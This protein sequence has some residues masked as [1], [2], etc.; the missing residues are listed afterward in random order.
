MATVKRITRQ[1]GRWIIGGLVAALLF[2]QL[3]V[4]AY[5]CPKLD[6]PAHALQMSSLSMNV[7]PDCHTGPGGMD[8]KAPQLCR[9]HCGGDSETAPSSFA[10]DINSLTAQALCLVYVVPAV[11]EDSRSAER[12]AA[13]AEAASPPGFPPLYLTLQVLRN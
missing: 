10:P 2:M 6:A 11:L 13:C 9:I 1:K 3:A 5:A 12:H 7:M 4:A 8:E